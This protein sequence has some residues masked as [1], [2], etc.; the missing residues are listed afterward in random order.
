MWSCWKKSKYFCPHILESVRACEGN[1]KVLDECNR[2]C[3]C[4]N[5][6]MKDCYRI[7]KEFTSYTP[8]EKRRFLKA[9]LKITTEEPVKSR[10][11]KFL[12]IHSKWFWKGKLYELVKS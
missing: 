4:V 11:V 1:G 10:L 5:G 7:R 8:E 3:T 6:V 2:E 9:Y 12:R